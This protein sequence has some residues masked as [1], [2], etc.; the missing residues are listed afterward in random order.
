MSTERAME[1]PE[2]LSNWPLDYLL[3]Q[4]DSEKKIGSLNKKLTEMT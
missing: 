3:V 4:A 1:G 2:D